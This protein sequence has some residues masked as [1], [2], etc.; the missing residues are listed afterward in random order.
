MKNKKQK[1][2]AKAS[3]NPAR[4]RWRYAGAVIAA[5]LLALFAVYWRALNGPFVFDDN[6]LPFR[7]PSI[8]GA[9]LRAWLTGVRPLLM[10]SFWLNY[11]ISAAESYS[12][13]VLNVL[14]H[15]L[16][17]ALVY[18]FARKLLSY[19]GQAGFRREVLSIFAGGLF[20]LH[21]LQ[22]ESVSYIASRSE[23]LS[24]M[25]LYGAFALFLYRRSEAVSWRVA[26][27]VLA[28]FL[29]AVSTKE[30]TAVLPGLLLLTDYWWN[31]GFS[32]RGIPRNW[33]LYAPIGLAGALAVAGVA[34]VLRHAD[35]AGFGVK[36]LPWHQYFFT[37]CR[38]IWTYTR[39][40]F[41][42][43]GQ[44]ID[45]DYPISRT[46]FDHGAVFGLAALVAVV[47]AA[48]YYR[49]RYRLASYG[50]LVYL[51]L[52]APT[53]S[54]IPIKDPIAEHRLYLPMIGLIF[55]VLEF[56]GRWKTTPAVLTA[57][58]AAIL[59]A[60]GALCYSR[61]AVWSSS[62]ALWQDAVLKSPG[63]PR[64]HFQLA[65]AYYEQGRCQ[66]ALREYEQ[67]N[68]L[69]P[70]D[71][72]LLVDWSEALDCAGEGGPAIAMLQRAAAM[73]RTAH[74][75]ALIGKDYAK[76]GLYSESLEALHTAEQIDPRF[77]MT[78]VFRGNL[79]ETAGSFAAA[80][81]EYRHALQVNPNNSRAREALDRVETR[82][83]SSR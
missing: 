45:Y 35:T 52:L 24:V 61:N 32:F 43:W 50:V 74:V 81:S 49:R 41:F 54:I 56:L 19:T 51:L 15:F 25:F 77:E 59:A 83:R 34:Y 2:Q 1:L 47:A 33:R 16:N 23:T 11:R 79:D 44:T 48:F 80:A 36:G 69:A 12:Y 8:A 21:P 57:T 17:G 63:Q 30:H 6:F 31:P 42:P 75:Y 58:A 40:F 7:N 65:Y 66:E 72:R 22:T 10:I 13:H 68:R 46:L 26:A 70:A 71:Y 60:T 29:A 82:A 39:L 18:L 5:A 53:S 78:Y 3:R 28:L 76:Q 4:A 27:G 37:E 20:L 73:D 62:L 67:V 14:L 55:V 38:G 9:P 64:T